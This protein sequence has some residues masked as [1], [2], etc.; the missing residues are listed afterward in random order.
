VVAPH[1]PPVSS[2]LVLLYFLSDKGR[3]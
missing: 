3:T 2:T 1:L